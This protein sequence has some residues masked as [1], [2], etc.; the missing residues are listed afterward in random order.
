MSKPLLFLQVE[1]QGDIRVGW[2]RP[3]CSACVDLGTDDR[4]YV[5][6]GVNVSITELL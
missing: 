1:S 5:F 6:D 3:D 4:A 2:A